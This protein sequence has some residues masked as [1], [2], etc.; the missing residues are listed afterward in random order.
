MAFFTNDICNINTTNRY[1][2]GIFKCRCEVCNKEDDGSE[3]E[4][5]QGTG[6]QI[7]LLVF[8]VSIVRGCKMKL[9]IHTVIVQGVDVDK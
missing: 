4:Q 5:N 7:K 2:N 9:P 1:S 6:I 8:S 3:N